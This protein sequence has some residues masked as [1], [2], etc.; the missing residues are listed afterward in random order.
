AFLGDDYP[1]FLPVHTK[2]VKVLIEESVHYSLT[3]L[4]AY[5]EWLWTA[6]VGDNHVRLGSQYRMFA[7]AYFHQQ[8]CIRLIRAALVEPFNS[9]TVGH[10]H[11][12]FNYIRQWILC[13]ADI[14]LERGDFSLRNF[15]QDRI[16]STH[17]CQDW[18]P[19]YNMLEDNW[20]RWMEFR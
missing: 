10:H 12:C 6:P 5:D 3:D 1:A 20:Y 13:S 8:H 11:H 7:V 16:G 4:E 17:T 18:E 19:V 9:S 2:P 15:T 14:T